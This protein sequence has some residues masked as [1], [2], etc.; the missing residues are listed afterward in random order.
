MLIHRSGATQRQEG[1]VVELSN[2]SKVDFVL[3]VSV[4]WHYCRGE[5]PGTCPLGVVSSHQIIEVLSMN[6]KKLFVI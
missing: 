6:V 2:L 5:T 4:V 3:V 1:L